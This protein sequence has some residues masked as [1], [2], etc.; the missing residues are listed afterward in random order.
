MLLPALAAAQEPM[1]RL[2]SK[3]YKFESLPTKDG[4]N[5][6]SHAVFDG[7]THTGF[8]IEVHVTE[9][10]AGGSPHPPHQHIHEEMFLLQAGL[11]D[12]TVNGKTERI[13]PG[14]VFFVNSNELHGVKNPG[15][16]RAEYFVVAMGKES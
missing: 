7:G 12:V 11:L 9:L 2:P 6:K 8:R 13:T 14:S 4:A 1:R 3:A 5:S 10:P 16:D 15:P